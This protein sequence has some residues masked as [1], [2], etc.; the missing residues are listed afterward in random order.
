[1]QQGSEVRWKYLTFSPSFSPS[2]CPP[3][4]R[5]GLRRPAP[6]SHVLITSRGGVNIEALAIIE[7]W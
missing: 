5:C 2:P 1:S 3:Q 7:A 4:D 6:I